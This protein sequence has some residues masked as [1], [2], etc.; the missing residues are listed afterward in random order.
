MHNK[1]AVL[2]ESFP[3]YTAYRQRTARLPP[4]HLL[5]SSP[6]VVFADDRMPDTN[7]A[8]IIG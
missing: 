2:A 6:M 8:K 4:R 7:T 3:D 5:R 1:E